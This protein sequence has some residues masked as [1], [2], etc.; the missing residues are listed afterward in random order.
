VDEQV[1]LARRHVD[2]HLARSRAAAAH[3]LPGARVAVQPAIGGLIRVM[4]RVH[5]ARGLR[6]QCEPIDAGL[7]FAGEIQD[8]QEIVGNLI[9]NACKWARSQVRVAAWAQPGPGGSRL[10][11]TIDDDGPGV[12]AERRSSVMARGAR[13][14]ESVPG[15]GLGLAIVQELVALYGG[16]VALEVAD[17][18]GLRVAIDLPGGTA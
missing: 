5:A 2:W 4:Q 14:D 16:S 1:N 18:G 11:I 17:G 9:D 10:R 15:S 6:I 7:G 3:G 13:L 12:A 8:L